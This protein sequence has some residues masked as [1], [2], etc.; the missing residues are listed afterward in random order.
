MPDSSR[1]AVVGVSASRHDT[2]PHPAH[3]CGEK[4]LQA[5]VD[6]AGCAPV[7][8]PALANPALVDIFAGHIDGLLLTGGAANVEPQQYD[9]APSLEGTLHD[10]YRD[11]S[12]LP[13]IRRCLDRGVPIL[14]LCLGIQEINVARGGTLHQRIVDMPDRFDHRMRRDVDDHLQRYRPAHAVDVVAGGHLH[15]LTGETTILVNSLHGQAIDRLG[16]GV[17]VEAVAADGIVEAISIVDTAGFAIGVQWHP[18]WPR[19]IQGANRRIFE[20]FGGACRAFAAQRG[21]SVPVAAE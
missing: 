18:E 11:N 4:Y 20:A 3:R 21:G 6:P 5:V 9:G 15:A 1:P 10:R 8:L 12:I 16:D 17:R 13:L 2:G 7:I 19:P 14:G